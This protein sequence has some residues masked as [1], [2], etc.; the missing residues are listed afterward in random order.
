MLEHVK[1]QFNERFLVKS[2]NIISLWTTW[3]LSQANHFRDNFGWQPDERYVRS[4][5]DKS[6]MGQVK[7]VLT[8]G[9]K[10]ASTTAAASGE[11]KKWTRSVTETS[12]QLDTASTCGTVA[13]KE[14]MRVTSNLTVESLGTVKRNVR[15]L[16]G[17]PR[18]VHSKKT[19]STLL[20]TVTGC[21][22]TRCSTSS[23]VV[24]TGDYPVRHW[25]LTQATLSLSSAEA[26]AKAISKGCVVR[27]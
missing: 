16:K 8:S 7:A 9:S 23:R 27:I 6:G 4:V 12:A 5:L 22:K 3:T 21:P 11:K 13:T 19:R 15:Y 26:A 1:T 10:A 2:E 14:V 17:R 24:K 18:C 25:S 20:W